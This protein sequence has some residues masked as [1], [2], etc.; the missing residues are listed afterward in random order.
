MLYI[1]A[2]R[3]PIVQGTSCQIE[4]MARVSLRQYKSVRPTG[5]VGLIGAAH[6][7]FIWSGQNS[8]RWMLQHLNVYAGSGDQLCGRKERLSTNGSMQFS[9]GQKQLCGAVSCCLVTHETESQNRANES[10]VSLLLFKY[11]AGTRARYCI[12]DLFKNWPIRAVFH[13]LEL[14]EWL[15]LDW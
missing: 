13:V 9:P 3:K 5:Q 10:S 12:D 14:F 7:L 1:S 11:K 15:K 4:F 2:R 6:G 8:K